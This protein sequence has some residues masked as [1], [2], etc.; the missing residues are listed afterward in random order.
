VPLESN[1]AASVARL[2]IRNAGRFAS[3]SAHGP[4]ARKQR[5]RDAVLGA[6]A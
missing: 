3:N 4:A 2:L 5:E 6:R 1:E